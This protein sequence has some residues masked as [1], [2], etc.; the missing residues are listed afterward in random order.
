MT[1]TISNFEMELIN[2]LLAGEDDI[3]S[4]L[5]KQFSRS[6]IQSRTNTG[7]GFYTTFTIPE[8]IPR[9]SDEFPAVKSRFCFGDVDASLPELKAGAGFLIWVIDGYLNQL[10]GYT[11]G[12]KWPSELSNYSLAYSDKERNIET[13]RK[14]WLRD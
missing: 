3:L 2:M 8:D 14:E 10:E 12:E 7:A 11:Y 13:L 9:V 4:L 1:I 6:T 5:R